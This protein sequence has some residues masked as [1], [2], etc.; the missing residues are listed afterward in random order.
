MLLVKQGVFVKPVIPLTGCATLNPLPTCWELVERESQQCQP[1]W[2]IEKR[3]NCCG[4]KSL[5]TKMVIL[6]LTK[7]QP[8]FSFTYKRSTRGVQVLTYLFTEAALCSLPNSHFLSL[9][10]AVLVSRERA[11]SMLPIP[12]YMIHHKR[13]GGM[14]AVQHSLCK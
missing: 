8:P 13:G 2:K 14:E 4:S 10:G 9:H 6:V 3:A 5:L 1:N 11:G 7:H 12:P